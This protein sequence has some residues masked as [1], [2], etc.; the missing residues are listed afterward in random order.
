MTII[1][2]I[3]SHARS[4]I[5]IGS[6]L[7]FKDQARRQFIFTKHLLNNKN[8]GVITVEAGSLEAVTS[9]A[10]ERLPKDDAVV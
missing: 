2:T 10:E 5:I 9:A 3:V 7:F 4:T 6:L 8:G 1:G